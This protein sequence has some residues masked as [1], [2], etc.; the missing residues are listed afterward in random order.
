MT[1]HLHFLA[2][3]WLI[4]TIQLGIGTDGEIVVVHTVEAIGRIAYLLAEFLIP[5]T[6][7]LVAIPSFGV[8]KRRTDIDI[9]ECRKRCTYGNR[10]LHAIAPIRD[11]TLFE[12]FILL[13]R[14]AITERATIG[15]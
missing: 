8:V 14:D 4:E 15:E 6:V 9:L 7:H 11:K 10:V 3:K 2:Y 13:G 12:E 5:H 1:Y